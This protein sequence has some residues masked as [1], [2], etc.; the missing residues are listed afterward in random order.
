MRSLL[1]LLLLAPQEP[2]LRRKARVVD[3]L[4]A[5]LAALAPFAADYRFFRETPD[6]TATPGSSL[7]VSASFSSSLVDLK[8]TTVEPSSVIY[9]TIDAKGAATWAE[10]GEGRRG[11]IGEL[12]DRI[13]K[14]RD[15]CAKELEELL[16][17]TPERPTTPFP[18]S[19][20]LSLHVE[21]S[22]YRVALSFP[23]PPGSWLEIVRRADDAVMTERGDEIVFRIPSRRSEVVVDRATGLLLDFV[24]RDPDGS[25]RRIRR[26]RYAC[27]APRLALTPPERLKPLSF[28]E[29]RGYLAGVSAVLLTALR[30]VGEGWSR[31]GEREAKAVER[32]SDWA[33]RDLD[34]LQRLY[35][36]KAAD[37]YVHARLEAEAPLRDLEARVDEEAQAFAAALGRE[38][39]FPKIAEERLDALIRQASADVAD[40]A[41]RAALRQALS[42]ERVASRLGRVDARAA[43]VDALRRARRI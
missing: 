32:I 9:S 7:S 28:R 37:L 2:D 33:G 34:L 8:L 24:A 20:S 5:R 14:A 19:L 11:D 30:R 17:S 39:V 16:P 36:E 31:L 27:P 29:T 18:R 10:G 38:N 15:L 22:E 35:V 6:G 1:A 3:N 41:F 43:V 12:F 4:E 25:S 40:E 23:G 13:R 26:V 42:L 21:E